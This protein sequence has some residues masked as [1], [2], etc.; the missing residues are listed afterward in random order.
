MLH[1]ILKKSMNVAEQ[2][3][4]Q[5]MLKASGGY[6]LHRIPPKSVKQRGD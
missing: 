5:I 1:Y 4:T 3:S 2:I 6:F